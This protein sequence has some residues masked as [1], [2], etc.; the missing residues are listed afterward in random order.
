MAYGETCPGGLGG[1][2]FDGA[3][4]AGESGDAG[5]ESFQGEATALKNAARAGGIVRRHQKSLSHLRRLEQ[6]N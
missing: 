5:D 1:K 2:G 3:N 4:E 6:T